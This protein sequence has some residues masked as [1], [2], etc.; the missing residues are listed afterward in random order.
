MAMMT[1]PTWMAL[2]A[3]GDTDSAQALNDV[4]QTDNGG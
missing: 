2:A 3:A 1:V 4:T